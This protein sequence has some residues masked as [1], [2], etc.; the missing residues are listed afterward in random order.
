MQPK[1]KRVV[2][3]GAGFSGLAS[4]GILA[5]R[6]HQV[7]VIERQQQVGGRSGRIERAGF[8][9]DTGPSWYLMPE[10]FERYYNLMGTSASEQLSLRRLPVGY[11]TFF[12]QLTEPVDVSPGVQARELF[13]RLEPGSAATLEKYLERAKTSYVLALENFLYT[14]FHSP[15]SFLK[16]GLL[17]HLP[18]LI[19][20]LGGNL[21]NYV[22]KRFSRTPTR[23]IL[24]YPAVFLGSSPRRTP[25]LYQLMSHLDL[26]E[27]VL[28]PMGGFAAVADSMA[29][30]AQGYGAQIHLGASA[31]GI[32][33]GQC[34]ERSTAR[35]G[36]R[37]PAVQAVR[38]T[39]RHGEEKF[40]KA[41]SVI[42]AADARHLDSTL[43]PESLHTHT[44][45]KFS[46]VDPGPSAVL[47]CLG[48]AGTLPQLEHHNLLF[49]ENWEE[50]FTRIE[51]GKPL[52]EET[53]IYVCKPSAT[54]PQVAP[55]GCEN[56]FIL[57]PAPA[58]AA[59]GK[60]GADREGDEVVER[61]ADAAIKQLASWAKIEDLHSRILVRHTIGPQDFAHLYGASQG[62][63]LGLAHTL[64]QSA[65]FRP[66]NRS[67]TVSGLYYAGSTVR[68]GV[69]VPMCLISGELAAQAVEGSGSFEARTS[70]NKNSQ[71]AAS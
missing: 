70:T 39:D 35:G 62:G 67:T 56:L 17:K 55:E 42:G 40:T 12:E 50:N 61:I 15:G 51:L 27:G 53:S 37:K 57:I 66:A 5:A 10:V 32:I 14:D 45:T 22:A 3:I 33:T 71:W 63:A 44:A 49:T 8:R 59:W 60:G 20:L 69:G 1:A 2:V 64:R 54:D 52:A 29:Q 47:V 34:A 19:P 4:A 11:R 31:T 46:A 68:P 26:T 58:A 65:M 48:I 18:Q 24:G 28:Y 30:L 25:A 21:H 9:F 23:Q 7:T 6:G 41:D 36:G 38:W 16:P 13:E 43:L